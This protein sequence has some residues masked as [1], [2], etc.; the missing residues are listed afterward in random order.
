M[1]TDAHDPLII[2]LVKVLARAA[3]ERD[4]A[5]ERESKRRREIERRK[6]DR[7]QNEYRVILD[8][9][10]PLPVTDAELDLLEQ[11]LSDFLSKLLRG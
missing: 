1:K 4:F 10:D 9:P 7:R 3:A 5:K 6:A 2:E 8:L 11:E